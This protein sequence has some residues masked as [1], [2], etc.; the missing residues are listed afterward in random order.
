M[1]P[2]IALLSLLPKPAL[3]IRPIFNLA[4]VGLGKCFNN[5][6]D[7]GLPRLADL[8]APLK[9]EMVSASQ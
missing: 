1:I 5:R 6:K 9:A 2:F 8:A 7:F 3:Q 4:T